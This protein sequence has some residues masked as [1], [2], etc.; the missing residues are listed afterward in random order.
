MGL[1]ANL[2]DAVLCER[3]RM[4]NV[5]DEPPPV[6]VPEVMISVGRISPDAEFHLCLI[7]LLIPQ[8]HQDSRR[9]LTRLAHPHIWWESTFTK[10]SP[11]QVGSR[12]RFGSDTL[13]ACVGRERMD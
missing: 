12:R 4:N 9:A 5:V 1:D 8:T 2:A 7:G 13:D 6:V 10:L 3:R 11:C